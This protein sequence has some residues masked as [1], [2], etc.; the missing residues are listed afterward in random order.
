[1]FPD[2]SLDILRLVAW[3]VINE[4]YDPLG[5]APLGELEEWGRPLLSVCS[6][7]LKRGQL[8]LNLGVAALDVRK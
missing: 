6:S 8:G 1:M 7:L 2:E 5:P 4:E 3:S